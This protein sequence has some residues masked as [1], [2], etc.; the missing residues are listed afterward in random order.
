MIPKSPK[1][2]GIFK[3]LVGGVVVFELLAFGGSFLVWYKLNNSREF[4]EKAKT[5]A[6]WAL[7]IY[8]KMGEI[9]NSKNKAIRDAD[10]SVWKAPP[11]KAD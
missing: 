9:M 11:N 2:P 4:R 5:S 3:R 6:P 8:Y 7:E 10:S 1:R